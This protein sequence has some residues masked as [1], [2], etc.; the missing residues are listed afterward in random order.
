MQLFRIPDEHEEIV[1]KIRPVAS[2][3]LQARLLAHRGITTPDEARV[4]LAP[5]YV[6]DI[7]DPFLIMNMDRAVER[8]L[9][10]ISKKETVCVWSD[11]DC[12]GIPGGTILYSFF[13][14]IGHTPYVHYIP[15]RHTEG[16]GLNIKGLQSLIDKG[17]TLTITVDSGITNVEEVAYAEERGMS[18]IVTDH[19][20]PQTVLPPAYAV[21]NSK[22]EFDTYPDRMLCGAA[23]AWKLVCALIARGKQKGMFQDIPEGWEKWLLDMAGLST[24]AD[25]VPLRHENRA[26]AHFGLKVLRKTKRP[27]LLQLL[28]RMKIDPTTITE[29]DVGFMIGP[30]INAA[31]RMDDPIEAFKLLSTEDEVE[32][33]RLAE[34]LEGINTDRKGA[35]LSV[36]KEARA[37]V[38]SRELKSVIVVGS[39]SWRV[40]VLGIVANQLMEHYKR[41]V[42]VW[43]REGS[44]HIKGS[45]RSDGTVNLVTLMTSTTQDLFIDVGGH[46]LAG[47]FSIDH[48]HIHLLEEEL[49]L[50]YEKTRQEIPEEI[51]MV[52]AQLAIDDVNHNTWKAIAPLAPFG[53]DN[54]KPLFSFVDIPLSSVRKFGKTNN[55]TEA[56]FRQSNGRPVNAIAFFQTPEDLGLEGKEP[57]TPVTFLA[58]LEESNFRGRT[59]LR[60]RIVDIK[61]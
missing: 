28:R 43:G 41:P 47:G 54:Q 30:R 46:E 44:E 49:V 21:I 36:V 35:T 5:D 16:Y 33:G 7:Y 19:H 25:M 60:L 1:E 32:G 45:C 37:H 48:K 12:D 27:G 50:A 24:I 39:P 20:L 53:I 8:V 17:V 31:S 55:H 42:F 6:R 22:Q 10:A 13:K 2:S 51:L 56:T 4:F 58:H 61:K 57:G 18:V 29:D 3:E 38:E 59:E 9:E 52:D 23:V 40:G 11:Y 34:F 15:H 14:K 26:I